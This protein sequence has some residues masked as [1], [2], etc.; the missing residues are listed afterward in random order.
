MSIPDRSVSWWSV[1]GRCVGHTVNRFVLILLLL[2][3]CVGNPSQPMPSKLSSFEGLDA[4]VLCQDYNRSRSPAVL[5]ELHQRGALS[6]LDG[7]AIASKQLVIGMTMTGA[8]CLYGTPEQ[9]NDT[10][11]SSVRHEQWV[12]CQDFMRSARNRISPLGGVWS[13]QEHDILCGEN[14]YLY[15]ENGKLTAHQNAVSALY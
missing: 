4:L 2:G 9:M 6:D 13:S 14:A 8:V 1:L 12:Y 5:A 10:T 7:R 3:G 11:T 15:F